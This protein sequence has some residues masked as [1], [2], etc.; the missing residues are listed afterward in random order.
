MAFEGPLQDRLLIR[1]LVDAYSDATF[2]GDVEAWLA[3]WTEDAVRSFGDHECR[4]KAALRAFWDQ[5]WT[6]IEKMAF[7]CELGALEVAGDRASGRCHT[8]EILFLKGGADRREVL[9]L[10]DD[11]LVRENGFWLFARR[12]YRLFDD[13]GIGRPGG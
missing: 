1:D 13:G 9:G 3:C 12:D 5:V 6:T 7:F 2:R 4:G 8:Q 10:Y 11:Q